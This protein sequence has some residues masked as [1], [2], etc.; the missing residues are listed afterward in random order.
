MV[1]FP[2]HELIRFETNFAIGINFDIFIFVKV[3]SCFLDTNVMVCEVDVCL[4]EIIRMYG[5]SF[6]QPVEAIIAIKI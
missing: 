6:A 3:Y 2:C 1:F 4:E 5:L